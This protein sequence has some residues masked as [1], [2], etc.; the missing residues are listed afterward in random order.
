[1]SVYGQ[2]KKSPMA[3]LIVSLYIYFLYLFEI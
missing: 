1:M 2:N 3:C